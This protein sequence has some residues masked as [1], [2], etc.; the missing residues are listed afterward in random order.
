MDNQFTMEGHTK[1][2]RDNGAECAVLLKKDGRFPL[3]CAG[4][5]AVYGS[6]ARHTI[7][8]GTGSGEINMPFVTVEN[9]LQN[10]GFRIT[11][12]EWLDAYD[13][14]LEEAE[15]DFLAA[16][17]REARKK[18]TLAVRL[19][20]GRSIREPDYELPLNGDGNT[21]VYVLSRVSGE[22]SDQKP[23]PGD[24]LLTE[25]EVRDI[26]VCNERYENFMLVLNTGGMI[27]LSPVENVKNI[28]LL[29]QLGAETGNILA[30]ILLGHHSPS[31]KLTATWYAWKDH[32]EMGEFGGKDDTAYREGI[33]VGYR[34]F[35]TLGIAPL[36]PFG[37]GL[38][39]TEFNVE[40]MDFSL[41]GERVTVS[42]AVTNTG[43]Y[44][45]KQVLQLYV[46]VPSGRLDQPYQMLAG[47]LKTAKLQPGET[48]RVSVSYCI[49][50]I[51]S[52]DPETEAY[53][54]E[55]GD[56]IHR[57]GADSQNTV[58]AGIVH[59]GQEI[60]CGKFAKA[61]GD[62][63]FQ[64]FVPCKISR[65]EEIPENTTLLPLAADAISPREPHVF[66]PEIDETVSQMTDD[67]LIKMN[68]GAFDPKGGIQSIIG[69]A[70][71]TVAGAA[72]QS[73]MGG[74]VL[75]IPSIVMADGTGGLRISK[76]YVRDEK[77]FARAMAWPFR[78]PS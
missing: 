27:D 64:D 20:M 58:I 50:D 59:I 54:L 57:I 41:D 51:A 4:K 56:Y 70:S 36:F 5:I 47:F 68:L 32:P 30:G 2:F 44:P 63:G 33:Y 14:V 45:G 67:Q 40:L 53:L 22:G 61:F 35:D 7:K 42:A 60:A 28:L 12:G 77:G 18:R 25:T 52:Y 69:N 76:E 6:G 1:Y 23:V 66:A 21:A 78:I 48:Q 15:K 75:G 8:G 62:P 3:D 9:G 19:A 34:Y 16:I 29:S 46:S 24:I 72:G 39:W 11:T 31:G 74:D 65:A 49:S 13:R 43:E 73:Y 10:A 71:F 17:K 37:Y 26:L 38:S 55:A